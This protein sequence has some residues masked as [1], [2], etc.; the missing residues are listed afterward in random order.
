M[1]NALLNRSFE[2]LLLP[3]GQFLV[4]ALIALL[5]RKR[6]MLVCSLFAFAALQ[7]LILSLPITASWLL[8][9]LEKQYPPRFE[10]WKQEPLPQA[11]V[12]LGSGRNLNVPE[13]AGGESTSLAGIERLRYAAHLPRATG[14]P[15]LVTGGS[16]LPDAR[17]EAE[18]M[19]DVLQDEF[20]VPVKWLETESHTT[21][22]NAQFTDEM[23][24]KAGIHSAWLV[25]QAWHM[26]RS[27]YSFRKRKLQYLPASVSY[28]GAIQ[29]TD[30]PMKFVPQATA[31]VRSSIALHEWIGLLWYSLRDKLQ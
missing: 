7:I 6:K 26:P 15:I 9:E 1:D 28:S 29:W 25:T 17:S 2:F 16:P 23:L 13:Y 3:P 18:L 8:G 31:L 24:S 10:L 27:L 20:R 30:Y 12:V 19:R 21:W 11:I 5:W 14:L 22:Q 4:L